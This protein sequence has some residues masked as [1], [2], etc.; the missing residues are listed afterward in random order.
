MIDT[1]ENYHEA[2]RTEK[3]RKSAYSKA[4]KQKK[5]AYSAYRKA[6]KGR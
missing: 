5:A 3:E 1:V 4:L 6:R 2:V